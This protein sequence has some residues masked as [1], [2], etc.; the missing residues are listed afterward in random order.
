MSRGRPRH[1]SPV[2]SDNIYQEPNTGCWLWV[3][4][5]I[6]RGYGCFRSDGKTHLAHRYSYETAVGPIGDMFVCHKCDVRACVNPDHLFLGTNADNMA[7]MARKGR[8]RRES[9][10][11]A[12]HRELLAA[13]T[14]LTTKFGKPPSIREL[15]QHFG[16]RSIQTVARRLGFLREKG[17]VSW[18]PN[19]SRTIVVLRSQ[20]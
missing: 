3:G 16:W 7:D 13:I 19:K 4:P 14:L 9:K 5:L 17:A 20:L 1:S 11:T 2:F 8:N 10:P 6:G 18:L 15:R 12:N